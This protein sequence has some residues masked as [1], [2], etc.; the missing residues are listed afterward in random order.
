MKNFVAADRRLGFCVA[1]VLFA[2]SV[3][4]VRADSRAIAGTIDWL[5]PTGGAYPRLIPGQKL[6]VKVSLERQRVYIMDGKASVYTM[7]A[8]TGLDA[9]ADDLTPGGTFYIQRE[10]G[11]S[12]FTSRENEGARYWVSWFH[13]GEY[14]FHS[15]PT[16][17]KGN[18]IAEEARKLGG[19]ASHGCIRLSLSDA[20][21]IYTNIK[22]GT[23]VVIGP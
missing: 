5:K 2:L 3:L 9:P 21:W 7:I 12:F 15:V 8:S 19:K 11:L 14:L 23:K 18:I 16:D 13:H 1:A 20:K 4:P 10:R 6:W 17:K 22:F